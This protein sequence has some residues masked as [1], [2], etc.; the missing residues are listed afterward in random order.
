MGDQGCQ[1]FSRSRSSF[2][3]Y[4]WQSISISALML[5]GGGLTLHPRLPCRDAL[6][7]LFI[8]AAEKEWYVNGQLPDV[9][10]SQD[11]LDPLDP[12]TYGIIDQHALS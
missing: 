4:I 10:I 3:L 7:H 11:K 5:L 2:S 12:F 8:T 6:N 1:S 9:Y